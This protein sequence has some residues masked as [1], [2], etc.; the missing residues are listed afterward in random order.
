MSRNIL[1]ETIK[2]DLEKAIIEHNK[3][4][5]EP[6][7][8]Q[9]QLLGNIIY[10]Y[11]IDILKRT[12]SKEEWLN[13]CKISLTNYLK[14]KFFAEEAVDITGL[15]EALEIVDIKLEPSIKNMF[16]D[17]IIFS[18]IELTTNIT[19]KKP[20]TWF[21]EE[22]NKDVEYPFLEEMNH[23]I[24]FTTI[25]EKTTKKDIIGYLNLIEEKYLN[26][27]KQNIKK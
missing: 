19:S 5:I 3:N 20:L 12:T 9:E 2:N 24:G 17:G 27:P 6:A 14:D 26:M 4:I 18:L 13:L 15:E 8:L 21:V 1:L 7:D 10:N 23:S 25:K 22:E 16:Y 11:K